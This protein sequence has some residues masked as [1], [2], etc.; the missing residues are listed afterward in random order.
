M[1]QAIQTYFCWKTLVADFNL[2]SNEDA[3]A[4]IRPMVA[5]EDI[6][7]RYLKNN[8][9]TWFVSAVPIFWVTYLFVWHWNLS[10]KWE[11]NTTEHWALQFLIKKHIKDAW[12]QLAD[13]PWLWGWNLLT[14]KVWMFDPRGNVYVWYHDK[15]KKEIYH[16]CRCKRRGFHFK[17]YGT[18]NFRNI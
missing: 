5:S 16:V 11:N 7:S 1:P 18:S 13:W 2:Y 10:C 15:S 6:T 17:V 14:K 4:W 8:Y 9:E 3:K 12:L